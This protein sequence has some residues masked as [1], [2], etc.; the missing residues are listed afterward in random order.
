MVLDDCLPFVHV[1]ANK[2]DIIDVV[3]EYGVESDEEVDSLGGAEVHE[4]DVLDGFVEKSGVS[5][6]DSE[7]NDAFI[8]LKI[9]R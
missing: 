3:R 8:V 6:D 4:I 7:G 9:I 5:S 1:I 2:V